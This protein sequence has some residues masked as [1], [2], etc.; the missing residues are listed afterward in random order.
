[1]FGYVRARE[2]TLSPEGIRAYQAAY[3]GLCRA[4]GRRRGWFPRLFLHYDFAFLTMLLAP[5][6]NP[7]PTPCQ[8][9]FLHPVQGRPSCGG[10]WIDVVADESVI[11][12][13]WKLQ[14]TLQDGTFWER[15]IARFLALCLK[16]AYQGARAACPDFDRPVRTLLDEL[17]QLEQQACTSLDRTAD[18]FARLLQAAAPPSGDPARDRILAQMLYHIGRWIY[19]IDAV[20]DWRD[21]QKTGRYNPVA[22]R[23]PAWTPADQTYLRT[24]MRQ[25]RN[26][27][28]AAF[29][30]LDRTAWTPVLENILYSGL[31]SV[32]ELVFSG[33]W[34]QFQKRQKHRKHHTNTKKDTT[35]DASHE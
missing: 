21:D 2:D 29:Q 18:C 3:C 28:G 34:R 24:L 26:L 6:E 30:L 13:Y 16:P 35:G 7:G 25:S 10:A 33:R 17:H 1:M 23:F 32:E 8:R 27:A 15:Q 5:P 9:C 12:S 4:L 19:L 11:L 14:D 31:P 22:A 20:D